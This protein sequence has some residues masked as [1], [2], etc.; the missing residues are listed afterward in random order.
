M[1]DAACVFAAVPKHAGV[2]F[3]CSEHHL[4]MLHKIGVYRN[5]VF[6][7]AKM[8]PVR[9]RYNL[10]FPLLQ[11]YDVACDIGS[12]TVLKGATGKADCAE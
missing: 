9:L 11:E 6:R 3:H 4:R 5:A 7:P 2:I 12:R 8:Y 10:P 1:V